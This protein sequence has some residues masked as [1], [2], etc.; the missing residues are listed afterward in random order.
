M[1][2]AVQLTERY[3]W[4]SSLEDIER[5]YT[6]LVNSDPALD[7]IIAEVDGT[8]VGHARG[9]W[10]LE[11]GGEGAYRHWFLPML[12]PQW[13]GH[14]IWRSM[15]RWMAQRMGEVA[16][17]HPAGSISTLD[18]WT[19]EHATELSAL[20]LDEGFE[21]VRHFYQMVRPLTGELLDA[22]LPEGL[23]LRP[24][25]PDQYRV[26]W[27]TSVE[28]FRDHYGH[29]EP[30]ESQYEA[31]LL[32]DSI[33]TPDLWQIA[34]DTATNEIAGQVRT[35]IDAEENREFGCRRGHTEF[36]TCRR[37]YRR[38]GLA[39]A[40]IAESLRVL[41]AQGMEESM[42]MV[43]SENLSGA[44]KLYADCGYVVESRSTDWRK[45]L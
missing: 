23:E 9:S 37:P 31:W 4:V 43:D 8:M 42:L 16:Q 45:A 6:H 35:F 2:H 22:K 32:N 5:E 40:M 36:I 12:V 28:A 27:D 19:P 20:F 11:E 39:K 13:R 3:P 24:V 1:S 34:W 38:R 30:D 26:I 33:F 29:Y 41:K 7:M 10:L 44:T 25:Q 18:T 17:D 14:G 21:I 15:I